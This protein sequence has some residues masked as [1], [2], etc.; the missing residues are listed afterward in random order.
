MVQKK[1][2]QNYTEPTKPTTMITKA[3]KLCPSA[4]Q[5][6]RA[7]GAGLTRCH[8]KHQEEKSTRLVPTSKH[9]LTGEGQCANQSV[10]AAITGIQTNP[11]KEGEVESA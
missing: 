6:L 11:Q 9:S 2:K 4:Q 5:Q 7:L 3:G 1:G 8:E 10:N